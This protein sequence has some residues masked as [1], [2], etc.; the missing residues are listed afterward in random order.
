MDIS[1]KVKTFSAHK[2]L[3]FETRAKK[4]FPF[5]NNSETYVKIAVKL[6]GMTELDFS[7][8]D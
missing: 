2:T 3:V 4:K 8:Q 1:G 7:F 6:I 5:G